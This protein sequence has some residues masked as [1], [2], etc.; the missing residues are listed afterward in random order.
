[1]IQALSPGTL[2]RLFHVRNTIGHLSTFEEAPLSPKAQYSMKPQGRGAGLTVGALVAFLAVVGAAA[3][4]LLIPRPL[5]PFLVLQDQR[6]P[7]YALA[8]SPDGRVLASGGWDAI[9]RLRDVTNWQQ[10]RIFPRKVEIVGQI[11]VLSFSPNGQ[12]LAANEQIWNTST[13]Q[14]V[15]TMQ[16]ERLPLSFSPGGVVLASVSQD[17]TIDLSDAATGEYLRRLEGRIQTVKSLEF[18]KD[19][20]MI[21][22]GTEDGIIRIWDTGS[23]RLLRE[24]PAH[25]SVTSIA[26]SPDGR[27]LA[28]GG[29]DSIRLWDPST[30]NLLRK[31]H[32]GV[33]KYS[34]AFSPDGHVLASGS[35]DHVRLWNPESARLL[36]TLSQSFWSEYFFTVVFSPSGRILAACN[37]KGEIDLWDIPSLN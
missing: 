5:R 24:I 22:A 14:V 4:F 9:V 11:G 3:W 12:L 18:S 25:N 37:N 6:G 23:G 21:A 17:Q 16:D 35:T 31:I 2:G 1:M 34:L 19:G 36:R 28:S 26:F 10:T 27:M 8:F 29:Y 15:R 13:G 20:N 30:G 33:L 32:S 7:V